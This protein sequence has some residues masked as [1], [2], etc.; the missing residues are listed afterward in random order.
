MGIGTRP[1]VLYVDYLESAPWNY[2]PFV[3]PNLPRYRG[4]GGILIGEAIRISLAGGLRGRLGLYSLPG[5]EG[6]YTRI[7]MRRLFE[8]RIGQSPTY[9]CWY[10]EFA[11][12]AAES[13]LARQFGSDRS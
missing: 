7:G 1:H 5:S 4:V 9:G 10:F 13:Y 3:R 8:D 11:P 6:F 2:E 12:D